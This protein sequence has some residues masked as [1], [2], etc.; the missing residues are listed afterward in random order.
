MSED[1]ET[2]EAHLRLRDKRILVVDDD[3]EIRAAI[4]HALAGR[5]GA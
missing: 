1:V 4:D 3:P 2:E 5:R